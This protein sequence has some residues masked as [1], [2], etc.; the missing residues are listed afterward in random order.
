MGL[1]RPPREG[2][3][4]FAYDTL[5]YACYIQYYYAQM[6]QLPT[7]NP[8]VH[9]EFMH[10]G[11]SVQLSSNNPFGR[12]QV[13]ETIEETANKDMQMLGGTKGFSLK[14]GAVSRYYLTAEYRA[15]YPR[16][17]RDMICQ[18][19]SKLP[20]PDMQGRMTRKH[21]ADIKSLINLMGNN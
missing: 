4:C 18:G 11:F 14:P 20:Y 12:I 21:E 13:D 9:A 17:L 10:G 16:T 1:T 6:Y 19:N 7:T 8:D 2:A 3:T 15:V 5:N